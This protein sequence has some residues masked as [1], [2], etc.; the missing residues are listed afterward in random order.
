MK[1]FFI[2]SALTL[3]VM[4]ISESFSYAQNNDELFKSA[5]NAAF[6]GERA[7]A[8]EICNSI[9]SSN[10]LYYDAY[11]LA[12]RTYAWDKKFEEARQ[13]LS[14]VL[15]LK[16]G[17]YDAVDAMIDLNL[18]TDNYTDA[19]R[20]ADIGLSKDPNDETFLLKKAKALYYLKDSKAAVLLLEKILSMNPSNTDASKFL[21]SIKDEWKINKATVN[22]A[23]DIYNPHIPEWHMIYA[24]VG[25][26]TKIGTILAR[27]NYANRFGTNGWQVEADA[28]PT[29]RKGTYLYLNA[30]YS[31]TNIFPFFRGGFEIY[32]KLPKS[33]ETS[34]GFRYL[35]FKTTNVF[36]YTGSV[37]KYW[38]DYWFSG[39]VYLTPSTTSVSTSLS[40][41]ARRYF[42][43]ADDY[44]SLNV[45]YGYSPDERRMIFDSGLFYLK[46]GKVSIEFQHLVFKYFIFSCGA[47]YT[48]EEWFTAL[49]RDKFS[50]DLGISYI[51]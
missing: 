25:R 36:I 19:V 20:F 46:S 7:K 38:S 8:R 18:W 31:E 1:S 42:R 24:Q 14:K 4:T 2:I 16:P 30:G 13:F 26:R 45:G 5:Q 15:E 3:F 33:F 47:G 41:T 17:Y 9:I 34:L 43:T 44:L 37:G 35:D 12:G 21:Q 22:Y 28:Y 49:Y 40:L 51:F 39:R 48:N 11:V 23:I 27:V 50:F 32:Q 10:Q 29:I 6:G